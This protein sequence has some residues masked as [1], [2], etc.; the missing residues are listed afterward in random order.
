MIRVAI[1]YPNE[2]G[3]KFDGDYYLKKHIP[4]LNSTLGSLGLERT[5]VDKG[6]AGMEPG[7]PPPFIAICYMYFEDMEAM[8][9]S[10]SK[11]GDLMSDLPNFSEVQPQVQ[12]SEI[13]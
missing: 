13:A 12:I 10:M 5:E 8:Q 9:N 2:P 3:K 6:I 1:M 4:L 11:S 7:S